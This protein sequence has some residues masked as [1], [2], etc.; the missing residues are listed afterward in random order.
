MHDLAHNSFADGTFHADRL[1]VVCIFKC[2]HRYLGLCTFSHSLRSI[3]SPS[4]SMQ[5]EIEHITVHDLAHFSFAD[6][7]FHAARLEV[8]GIFKCTHQHLGLYS[9]I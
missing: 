8:L 7:T 1:E 4:P 2:A 3:I 9:I 5:L 6:G